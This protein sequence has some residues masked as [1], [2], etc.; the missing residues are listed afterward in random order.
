MIVLTR[1]FELVTDTDELV[2]LLERKRA[3]LAV[4]GTNYEQ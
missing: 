3:Q 4:S 1:Q 2:R